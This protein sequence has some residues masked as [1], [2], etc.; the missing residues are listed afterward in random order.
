MDIHKLE[1]ASVGKKVAEV[2]GK[3]LY[4]EWKEVERFNL[5]NGGQG[6][7]FKL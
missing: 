3:H 1:R 7:V 6:N 2:S 5:E 4:T